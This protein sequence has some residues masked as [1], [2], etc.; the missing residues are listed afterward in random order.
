MGMEYQLYVMTMVWMWYM[1]FWLRLDFQRKIV[2]IRCCFVMIIKQE[3]GNQGV[4][5][6]LSLLTITPN[7]SLREQICLHSLRLFQNRTQ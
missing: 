2:N 7:D 6:G 4:E 3:S 5:V 1:S